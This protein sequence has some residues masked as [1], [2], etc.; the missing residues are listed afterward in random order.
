MELNKK[1]KFT[2]LPILTYLS[3][4]FTYFFLVYIYTTYLIQGVSLY[5][6]TEQSLGLSLSVVFFI[7]YF[8]GLLVLIVGDLKPGNLKG[9]QF[10]IWFLIIML[11]VFIGLLTF[12]GLKVKPNPKF[13]RDLNNSVFH[14]KERVWP[15]DIDKIQSTLSCCGFNNNGFNDFKKEKAREILVPYSC[16]EETDVNYKCTE[17]LSY[18]TGC[19]EAYMSKFNIFKLTTMILL[20]IAIPF[21]L[22]TAYLYY[23]F[24]GGSARV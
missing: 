5:T 24:V 14:Y 8:I 17:Q 20:G 16:C 23:R 12:V 15:M 22:L 1:L 2:F 4:L 6:G 18:E 11:V 9:Y 19:Y 3:L 10:Y 13:E 21:T 7:V